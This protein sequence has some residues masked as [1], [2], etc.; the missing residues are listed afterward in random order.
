MRQLCN[1]AYSILIE[2]RSKPQIAQLEVILTPP[3]SQAEALERQ[4]REA[5]KQLEAQMG[6]A[7]ML[8]KPPARPRPKKK[9]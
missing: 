5:M 6:G 3:E 7:G 2:N 8:I 4:N 9:E 1:L